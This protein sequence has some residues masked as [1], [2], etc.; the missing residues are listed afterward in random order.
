M[1]DQGAAVHSGTRRTLR[2]IDRDASR[3]ETGRSGRGT[4][5]PCHKCPVYE[6]MRYIHLNAVYGDTCGTATAG[7]RGLGAVEGVEVEGGAAAPREFRRTSLSGGRE[8]GAGRGIGEEF[9]EAASD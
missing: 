4:W 6:A 3:H 9:A 1:A 5:P 8:L 7:Y 2:P